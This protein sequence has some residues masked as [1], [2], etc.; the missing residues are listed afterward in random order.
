M[1]LSACLIVKN[2]EWTLKKCLDSLIGIVDEIIIV[3]TGSTDQTVAIATS[4]GTK[5]YS[6]AWDDNFANARN[7]SM[8]HAQ[9]DYILYIDADEYLDEQQKHTLRPFLEDAR[10]DGVIM[11][12]RNYVGTLSRMTPLL[13]IPMTRVFRRGYE[14][15]GAIHEQILGIIQS[16]GGVLKELEVTI[17]HVGYLREFIEKKNKIERNIEI[18]KQELIR[19]PS[20]FFNHTNLLAEYIRVEDYAEA[21]RRSAAIIKQLNRHPF[22]RWPYYAPRIFVHRLTALERLK[23][24]REAML[25]AQEAMKRFPELA[26]FRKRFANLQMENGQYREA[27]QHLLTCREIG[28]PAN[29]VFDMLEGFGSFY[30][31]VDIGAIWLELGDPMSARKWFI[32]GFVECPRLEYVIIPI[33]CLMPPQAALL[34]EHIESRIG[35]EQ[36]YATYTEVY[37]AMGYPDAEQVLVRA[38]AKYGINALTLR[39]RMSLLLRHGGIAAVQQFTTNHAVENTHLLLGLCYWEQG[40]TQLARLS[41]DIAGERGVDAADLMDKDLRIMAG[42]RVADVALLPLFRDLACM[43]TDGIIR[44]L[45]PVASDL[46]DIWNYLKIGPFKHLMKEFTWAGNSLHECEENALQAFSE[47]NYAACEKWLDRADKLFQP[48]VTTCLLRCDMYLIRGELANARAILFK[49]KEGF[50]DSEMIKVVAPQVFAKVE[51][52]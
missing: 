44:R 21:E 48:T 11:K 43:Q 49:A 45:A 12:L 2:E 26:E 33:I 8:S 13:P 29:A 42:E 51:Q 34:H 15:T 38:E 23:R 35:D 27:L 14:F 19:D 16:Q 39:A 4:Y 9:G 31:A 41:F 32:Q 37:A 24:N 30:A 1:L 20:N 36:T 28:E 25:F 22:A 10:P 7:E 50:P 40:D 17:H 18:L 5:L 47:K 52:L 6:Y 46:K 3:D